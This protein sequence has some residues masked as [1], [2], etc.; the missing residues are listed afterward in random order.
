MIDE[1]WVVGGWSD[2]LTPVRTHTQMH[3][4]TRLFH[5]NGSRHDVSGISKDLQ[6]NHIWTTKILSS[7]NPFRFQVLQNRI[8]SFYR[9]DM[10]VFFVKHSSCTNTLY[11]YFSYPLNGCRMIVFC[12]VSSQFHDTVNRIFVPLT[13][14][15]IEPAYSLIYNLCAPACALHSAAARLR[16]TDRRQR[17]K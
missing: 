12:F 9:N 13:G 11:I 14:Q 15:G 5:S 1:E 17:E 4:A 7:S 16:R 3:A 6:Y 2:I 8:C 10:L